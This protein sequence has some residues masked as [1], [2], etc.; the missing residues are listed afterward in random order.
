V[1]P[2]AFKEAVLTGNKLRVTLPSASVVVL[3]LL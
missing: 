2:S 3:E 1:R